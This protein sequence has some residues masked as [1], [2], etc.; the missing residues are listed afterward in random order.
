[1]DDREQKYI[2]RMAQLLHDARLESRL[3][4]REA[5]RRAGT[6]HATIL[7]YENGRKVPSIAT[8]LR[9]IEA[10]GFA[11]DFVKASRIRY[12]DGI[13]RGDELMEVLELAAAFP[14]HVSRHM[15]YPKLSDHA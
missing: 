9:I 14:G 2:Q 7:A 10:Y 12:R 15:N 11:L 4:A 8:F 6:S 1:M 13:H 3:S 5:A